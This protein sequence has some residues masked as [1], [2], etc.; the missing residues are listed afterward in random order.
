MILERWKIDFSEKHFELFIYGA[1]R[2]THVFDL[3]AIRQATSN[4][5]LAFLSSIQQTPF[6]FSVKYFYLVE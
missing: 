5:T 3:A 2:P 4:Q 1:D 6:K